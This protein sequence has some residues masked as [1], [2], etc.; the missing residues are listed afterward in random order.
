[1]KDFYYDTKYADQLDKKVV[2][3]TCMQNQVVGE[4]I[5]MGVVIIDL[6]SIASGPVLH[7]LPIMQKHHRQKPGEPATFVP[8][9]ARLRV[10]I[11]MH[12]LSNMS[13]MLEDLRLTSFRVSKTMRLAFKY[14]RELENQT[15]A[16]KTS[17][18]SDVRS[19]ELRWP[20]T[21]ISFY[22]SLAD[23]E[24]EF[25]HVMPVDGSCGSKEHLQRINIKIPFTRMLHVHGIQ[26]KPIDFTETVVENGKSNC[27][28]SCRMTLSELPRFCQLLGG[29]HSEH[30]IT[31]LPRYE[32]FIIPP[33]YH[34][35]AT[36]PPSRPAILKPSDSPKPDRIKSSELG[37]AALGPGTE[38]PK[39]KKSRD[40]KSPA[41]ARPASSGLAALGASTPNMFVAAPEPRKDQ[42]G[43]QPLS[44]S[45]PNIQSGQA[46]MPPLP[47]GWE[48]SVD[49]HGKVFFIDH[50]TKTTTW[51]HP[52]RRASPPRQRSPPPQQ[53]QLPVSSIPQHN[54]VNQ[55]QQQNTPTN[56]FNGQQG[57]QMPQQ[58][59]Q[60]QGPY[61]TPQGQYAPI[62]QQQYSQPHQYHPAQQQP[63]QQP[64]Q[65]Y[66]Q[67]QQPTAMV[68]SPQMSGYMQMNGQ[69]QMN[70]YPQANGYQQANGYPQMNA[71][72]A[73]NS[74]L[75]PAA[76]GSPAIKRGAKDDSNVVDVV[77]AVASPQGRKRAQT[78]TTPDAQPKKSKSSGSAL[79]GASSKAT[80][81]SPSKKKRK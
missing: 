33:N 26:S 25:F 42:I 20:A 15:R 55:P 47:P 39:A 75:V 43:Q 69:P 1:M 76:N 70:G 28:F 40:E 49:P 63:Y 16:F 60:Y 44:A 68:G 6:L 30:G 31:G 81:D 17:K 53:M 34:P 41:P 57:Q 5:E 9:G 36:G 11:E 64:Q 56:P 50:N 8:S 3:F 52:S 19:D 74:P 32:G 61:A 51:A 65:Q 71:Y 59:S 72:P 67:V 77:T 58:P 23:L 24:S 62:Q 18:P 48:M 13:V 35:E 7:D 22:T 29:I 80:V 10:E 21:P 38:M 46:A 27:T 45:S 37:K 2:S 54:Y 73:H 14:G 78:T 66:P 4:H 12:Q 79:V